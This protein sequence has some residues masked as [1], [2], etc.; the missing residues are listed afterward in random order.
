VHILDG[1]LSA[2]PT[3]LANFLACR[4]KTGLDV[5]VALGELEKPTWIDPLADALRERGQWHEQRYVETLRTEGLNVQ[6]LGAVDRDRRVQL[7][8]DAMRAGADVIVQAALQDTDWL[9][10]ADILRKVHRPSALGDWS[11]EVEDTK[12]SRETRGGTI[13]QLCVYTEL[14][15]AIQGLQPESFH[16]ISP[17]GRQSYRFNDF[18]AYYRQVK[19]Q[20]LDNARRPG[21]TLDGLETYPEPTEHCDFCRWFLR[22]TARRRADDH[23]TFV[24][25]LGRHHQKELASRDVK[26]LG[27]LAAVP[28]PLEFRPSRGAKETYEKLAHQARLQKQ[29][30]ESA[31]P[32]YELLPIEPDLGLA[33]LPAPRPGDL[34]LDLEGD[35]FGRAVIGTQPGE[36]GREYLFGLGRLEAVAGG[37]Q[38][39]G[40]KFT[41]TARWAFTDAEERDAFDAVMSDIMAALE[42]DPDVHVYH[43][44]HYEPSAFKRLMGRYAVRE[45]D[46]DRLLRGGRFV[47]LYACVR[48]ALRAGVER[49]S[50]KDLEPFYAFKRDVELDT[51]GDQRRI[52]EVALERNDLA[53]VTSPVRAAV[54]GYNKDDCRS[55]LELRQWLESL[56]DPAMP[57]PV[58]KPEEG[59]ERIKDRDRE[60]ER[61]RAA[62][63]DGI[64][65]DRA[66]RTPD[67]HARYL[68]AH[69]V[70]W[71]RVEERVAWGDYHRVRVMAEEDLAEEPSALVGLEL[72][73][74]TPPTG[75]A[76]AYVDRYRYPVQENDISKDDQLRLPS[77]EV[78][79]TVVA[80]DKTGCTIDIKKI[81]KHNNLHPRTVIALCI[82]HAPEQEKSIQRIAAHVIA[83]GIDDASGQKLVNDLLLA[84]APR[85]KSGG[86][87]Q[88]ADED[89]TEFA[90]RTVFDLD[91]SLLAIQGPPGAGKTFTGAKMIAALVVAGRKVGV[92]AT[93]HKVIRKLLIDAGTACCSSRRPSGLREPIHIAHKPGDDELDQG[94]GFTI[95]EPATNDLACAWLSEPGGRVLGGTAWMWA[96][97]Q[98]AQSVDVLL[99]DEAGQMSLANVLAVAPAA[100]SIVLLGDPCQLD[101][102]TQG[103]HPD[104][105]DVSSLDHIL[106]VHQTM[107]KERGIFLPTTWRLAPAICE[108]TS[109]VFYEGRL[110]SKPGLERQRLDGSARFTGAGLFVV[111][112]EHDGC[113]TASEEE[114]LAVAEIVSELVAPGV[115]W[116]DEKGQAHQVTARDILVV[117]PYNAHVQ[118]L[119]DVIGRSEHVGHFGLRSGEHGSDRWR[120]GT[121]DKFQGQQAPVV[122]YSMATSRP[123]DAP[124]G[125][126]FLYSLNRLNVATSRAQCACIVVCSPW[127]FEPE[128]R[129]PR[130]MQLANA[131]ARCR[132]AAGSGR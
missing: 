51:A 23:L 15:G 13:L 60:I 131:M 40:S 27:H 110:A 68:L 92:V 106:T 102:P 84:R 127:L 105:V 79:G 93:S 85:L 14:I 124:R 16:V 103:H 104:G 17:A 22:C 112:V 8:L 36:S 50:I 11:Y 24:A 4:H 67:Q 75:R 117:A 72:V 41:Y 69:L 62:L 99:V 49:Y 31:K 33:G 125:M 55:T 6:D 77:D 65:A 2:S 52:V 38:P 113:R 126:E 81:V 97:G 120:I 45:A 70:A 64:P 94:S 86:F 96:R 87:S 10:Y 28:V 59:S 89:P 71:Y 56:R 3:D 88:P 44:G 25:G 73:S 82:V 7:T 66:A 90:V 108:F 107:P 115:T 48:R 29:Q 53:G 20:F 109:E 74:R 37:L 116:T 91:D 101:Q 12:L 100:R 57:R 9:G 30:R 19:S 34:F 111:P 132:E 1:R 76:T 18:A 54:E 119:K 61:L 129:T 46:V 118:K 114:A 83:K 80:I 63:L 47:D 21:R 39:A 42:A 78:I 121:V 26:T 95:D 123:E 130:Q 35:P 5:L 98:F 32:V 128:C 122:I 43:Y 58:P